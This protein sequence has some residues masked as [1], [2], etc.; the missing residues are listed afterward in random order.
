MREKLQ[1][2]NPPKLNTILDVYMTIKKRQSTEREIRLPSVTVHLMNSLNLMGNILNC[3]FVTGR[4]AFMV[5]N[6]EGSLDVS[7]FDMTQISSITLHDL[8][9]CDQFISELA[10]RE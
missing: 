4:I 6:P 3:D 2:L 5:K 9:L 1:E 8:D 7:Y 10:Q